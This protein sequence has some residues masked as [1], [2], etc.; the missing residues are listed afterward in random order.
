MEM[1]SAGIENVNSQNTLEEIQKVFRDINNTGKY[2]YLPIINYK[3]ISLRIADHT[4][5]FFPNE[6]ADYGLSV[7]I[8]NGDVGFSEINNGKNKGYYPNQHEIFFNGNE[9]AEYII[10][11][12]L[13][14]ANKNISK[15]DFEKLKT[16][17]INNSEISIQLIDK[18]I[19]N[20]QNNENYGQNN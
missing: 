7:V 20:I 3:R 2:T 5:R 8:N 9:S 11:S 6:Q 12:I 17:T 13:D 15:I 14:Y 18:S 4:K 10:T 19:N 1:E 16:N